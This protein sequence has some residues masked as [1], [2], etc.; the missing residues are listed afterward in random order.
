[1]N[2]YSVVT[3]HVTDDSV[4]GV[5]EN[6]TNQLIDTFFFEEDAFDL[7][8]FMENGGAFDG[9]TPAFL[10][11]KVQLPKEDINQSFMREFY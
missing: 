6:T 8:E 11:A 5:Y 3:S 2:R 7:A 10:V 9:F 4:W 1:M